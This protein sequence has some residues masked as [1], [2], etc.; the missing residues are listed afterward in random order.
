MRYYVVRTESNVLY[1]YKTFEPAHLSLIRLV[2][3]VMRWTDMDIVQ[4]STDDFGKVQ[5]EVVMCKYISNSECIE[6]FE[7]S[8]ANNVIH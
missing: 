6:V 7:T 4:Y 2:E 5:S 1:I 8:G 3:G